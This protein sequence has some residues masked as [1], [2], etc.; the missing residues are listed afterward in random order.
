MQSSTSSCF[1]FPKAVFRKRLSGHENA[2]FYIYDVIFEQ[3]CHRIIVTT[4][5]GILWDF[6]VCFGFQRLIFTSVF[7]LKS[8]LLNSRFGIR[9]CYEIM[10]AM[11]S[12]GMSRDYFGNPTADWLI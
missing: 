4:V 7:V 9:G 8:S 3:L 2:N 5:V 10:F 12:L 6:Q 1:S 11:R